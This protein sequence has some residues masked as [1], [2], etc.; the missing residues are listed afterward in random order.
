MSTN[1]LLFLCHVIYVVD[2]VYI[3]RVFFYT[4]NVSYNI[5]LHDSANVLLH[6]YNTI[7]RI[8]LLT[9]LVRLKTP[10]YSVELW[11]NIKN[12]LCELVIGK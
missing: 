3:R 11:H 2:G 10:T 6:N 1:Y 12:K 9:I 5:N 8:F 7:V 4:L